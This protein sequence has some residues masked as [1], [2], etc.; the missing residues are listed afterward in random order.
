M[1]AYQ[2][3]T[4]V[5]FSGNFVYVLNVWTLNSENNWEI[6]IY[7]FTHFLTQKSFQKSTDKKE[8]HNHK[9]QERKIN[10]KTFSTGLI[11]AMKIVHKIIVITFTKGIL[12]VFLEEYLLVV[13]G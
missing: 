10:G 4:N 13:L 1:C 5:S 6:K 7:R 3:V 9:K 12:F 11:F 8:N 2:E